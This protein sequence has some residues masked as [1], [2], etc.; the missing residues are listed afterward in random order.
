MKKITDIVCKAI[1]YAGYAMLIVFMI[2]AGCGAL[3]A[4]ALTF[5]ENDPFNLIGAAAC[6]F[7]FWTIKSVLK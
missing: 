5:I 6:G 1:D 7:L 2:I 3:I 4:T